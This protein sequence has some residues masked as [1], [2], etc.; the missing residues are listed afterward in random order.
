MVIGHYW[1]ERMKKVQWQQKTHTYEHVHT[2][3]HTCTHTHRSSL[4][5]GTSLSD[6]MNENLLQVNRW[7]RDAKK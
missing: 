6:E 4:N 3:T 2:Y 1:E 7:D 5:Q